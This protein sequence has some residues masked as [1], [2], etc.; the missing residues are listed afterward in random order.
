M[1]CAYIVAVVLAAFELAHADDTPVAGIEC[2]Q[3]GITLTLLAEQPAIVTPTGIDVDPS[4]NIWAIASHTHFRPAE[5]D[6]P[7]HDEVLVFSQNGN[8]DVFYNKTRATMDLELGPNGFVY[9]A[10]RSRLLRVRDTDGDGVGDDTQ[11][12]AIL[13]TDAD[14]PHNGMSGLAWHPNGDLLFSLGENFAKSWT[15]TG[16]DGRSVQGT[17]EGGIFQCHADGTGLRRIARGLWNPFGVCV[18]S[19]GTI[20]AA[21]NDPGARP[22]CR[23]LH[24]V[25]GGNY[26]YQRAYG[27]APFHPFVCWNGELRGTLPMLHSVGEA[28]CG[29]TPYHNGLLVPSWADNRIDFYPLTHAGATFQTKRITLVTGTDS[30]RPVCIAQGSH[31]SF[32]L[33][34]WVDRSYQLHGLGR[35]WRL[36]IDP[37]KASWL[38]AHGVST[39]PH[40]A[41]LVKQLYPHAN[42]LPTTTILRLAKHDD[43]F[44]AHA[45]L[46][47]LSQRLDEWTPDRIPTL[48]NRDQISL[49]LAA[50]L[51][52]KGNR[53]PHLTSDNSW[54]DMFLNQD[55]DDLRFEALRWIADKKIDAYAP[56][57]H[58]IL[59]QPDIGYRLFEAAIATTNSLAGTPEA[60]ITDEKLLL[61]RV[62]NTDV[63]PRARAFAL[64]LV[65]PY[66]DKMDHALFNSL[67]QAKD[68]FLT[69][70]VV[71]TLIVRND[72]IAQNLLREIVTNQNLPLLTRADAASGLRAEDSTSRAMLFTLITHPMKDVREEALRALR[73]ATLS[74]DETE[75][76]LASKE[77]F[78]ESSDLV[79]AVINPTS[80]ATA[81]PS[82]IDTNAWKTRLD[83]IDL[84]T[85][86]NAGR[87]VF[88]SNRIGGCLTCHRHAGRGGAVGPD[89]S[90]IHLQGDRTHILRSIL[91]PSRDVAPQ[92]HPRMLVT[93]EGTIF[94]GLLLRKGGR[95]GKEFYRDSNGKEQSFLKTDIAERHEIATSMMPEGLVDRMTDREIRDTIAFLQNNP[96]TSQAGRQ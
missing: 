13:K 12:L 3:P 44:L 77:Q 66:S 52:N 28:P 73:F 50:R 51:R 35:L 26:G 33:T 59:L 41:T 82:R 18:R 21:E 80:F 47:A 29:I 55:D 23:L 19:D 48:D 32:Y 95:S 84:P 4:G 85:D 86:I 15:L 89:L 7:E 20:F 8:R 2:S 83:N 71:Q 92:Y 46:R 96:Q 9:L 69:N 88:F 17:G 76:L 16:I 64:R 90:E 93:H 38:P 25:E 49:L 42:G 57:I 70:E 45:A 78:D 10:E 22:P 5:Y 54:I 27:N 6:G 1:L 72:A 81:R 53:P 67:L 74:E 87:R 91:E 60:G 31:H 75:S 63:P 62:R 39:T 34:D 79:D 30:F 56:Q 68:D 61:Q 94:T 58:S 24:I 36:D 11:D 65:D 40:E 37:Q 14:Y 43:P